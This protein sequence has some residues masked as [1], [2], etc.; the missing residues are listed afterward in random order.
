[1]LKSHS[2][3]K[4]ITIQD[5]FS[6]VIKTIK[7]KNII[8]LKIWVRIQRYTVVDFQDWSKITLK[9]NMTHISSFK[10]HQIRQNSRNNG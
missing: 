1:M 4:F 5:I 6:G 10:E 8:V 2:H 3:L 9:I 7:T